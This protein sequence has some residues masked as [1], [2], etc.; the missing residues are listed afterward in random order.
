MSK[1]NSIP[2]S[3]EMFLTALLLSAAAQAVSPAGDAPVVEGGTARSVHEFSRCFA[4]TQERQARPWWMVPNPSGGARISNA[5]AD[6]VS[7]PYRIRFTAGSQGNQV[8]LFLAERDAA[9]ESRLVEAVRNC[10]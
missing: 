10:W 9:E 7:N 3:T 6:G 4:S 1:T 5:G 2:G 8:Q